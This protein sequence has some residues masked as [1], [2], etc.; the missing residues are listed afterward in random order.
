MRSAIVL[1]SLSF[2]AG[3]SKADK[4][5]SRPDSAETGMSTASLSAAA[6][7][8]QTRAI[9]EA[10]ATVGTAELQATGN[11]AGWTLTFPKQKPIP[12]RVVSVG[13]DSIVTEAAYESFDHKHAQIRS[14]AVN[15]FQG[16]KMVGTL[17]AHIQTGGVDSLIHARL[18]GTR[19]H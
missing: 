3:C 5:A 19:E 15:R 2:L 13:G 12:L 18:E 16:D 1:C 10:G 7:K 8:W 14:H 4:P 6:G 17:E 11:T 9:S